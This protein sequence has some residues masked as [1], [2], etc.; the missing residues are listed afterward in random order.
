[1]NFRVSS[2]KYAFSQPG[3]AKVNIYTPD[4]ALSHET[5][6]HIADV[7]GVVNGQVPCNATKDIV[8]SIYGFDLHVT[9]DD[10]IA[11][12]STGDGYCEFFAYQGCKL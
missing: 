2:G 8:F 3:T 7:L 1:L 4:F 6:E 12:S 9:P 11:E 5:Y 10:Y